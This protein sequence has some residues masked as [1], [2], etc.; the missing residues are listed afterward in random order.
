M[1][2]KILTLSGYRCGVFTSPYVV[3]FRERFQVDGEMIS[4]QE[5]A[6]LVE[7]LRP[8]LEEMKT[9]NQFVNEF[10]VVTAIGFLYFLSKGCNIV[11]LEVGLGEYTILYYVIKTPLAEIIT[12]ISLDHT[13]VLGDTIEEIAAKKAGIIKPNS[14]LRL[15][16]QAASGRDCRPDGAVCKN[17][18]P[19]SSRKS[20][21]SA[22]YTFRPNRLRFFYAGKT[23]EISLVG[24]HQVYNAV[25]V[26]QTM[27]LLRQ[28]GFVL[29]GSAITEG[30]KETRF[31]A[32][33]QILRQNPVVVVDGAHNPEGLQALSQTLQMI[34][35]KK[36]LIVGMMADKD[37]GHSLQAVCRQADEVICVPIQNPRAV[38][39][40]LLAEL[41]EGVCPSVSVIRN[42]SEAFQTA[43]DRSG[44]Q[45]YIIGCGSFFLAGEMI[46]IIKNR[47]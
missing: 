4:Q 27:E 26:I 2:A 5:L 9:R 11:C 23:Y 47:L 37:Y 39:P 32:R 15:L 24:A 44:E 6:A 45:D 18:Q 3:D 41:A 21:S 29:P 7:A 14:D 10:D 35:Q 36:N 12:S 40:E 42:L 30:L 22:D 13:R 38:R 19:A 43:L 17:R 20:Q 8:I 28:K 46:P 31:S 16:P 25:T 1:C 33:F 34:Q